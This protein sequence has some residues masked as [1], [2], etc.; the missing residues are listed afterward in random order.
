MISENQ[1]DQK[2]LVVPVE[3]KAEF[4]PS[5]SMMS[6]N[7][8]KSL[9]SNDNGQ[10]LIK[11]SKKKNIVTNITFKILSNN[12]HNSL[13]GLTSIQLFNHLG[14]VL[15]LDESNFKTPNLKLSKLFTD[16]L[17]GEG[18]IVSLNSSTFS[19]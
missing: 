16:N 13:V 19:I 11:I 14:E 3:E 8:S 12:G 4:K 18:W 17:K 1:R 5:S 10:K 7:A 15:S 6:D 2:E 9:L